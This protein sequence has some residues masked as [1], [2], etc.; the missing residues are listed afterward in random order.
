MYVC[1][2]IYIYI[3]IYIYI[4]TALTHILCKQKHIFILDAFYFTN[5]YIYIYNVF[6]FFFYILAH[7]FNKKNIGLG[8][9]FTFMCKRR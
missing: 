9:H 7:S 8:T 1:V 6:F 2:F 5:I 4:C 3:Y